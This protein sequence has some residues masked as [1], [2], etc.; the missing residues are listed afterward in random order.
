MITVVLSDDMATDTTSHTIAL[1]LVVNKAEPPVRSRSET[2]EGE[3]SSG[4]Y[5]DDYNN[6]YGNY[7]YIYDETSSSYSYYYDYYEEV[8]E[9]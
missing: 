6:E 4:D 8:A 2:Q 3:P 1:T 9:E 5:S 7:E